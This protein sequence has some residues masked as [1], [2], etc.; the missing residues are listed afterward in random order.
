MNGLPIFNWDSLI[1]RDEAINLYDNVPQHFSRVLI[2]GNSGAGKT[3]VLLTLLYKYMHYDALFLYYKNKTEEKYE[4]FRIFIEEVN[5]QRK[6]E[7][8]RQAELLDIDESQVTEPKDILLYIAHDLNDVIPLSNFEDNDEL[9][10]MT[11]IVVF[12]DFLNEKD[13]K[14]IS[15][16]MI[17]SRK[18]RCTCFYLGQTLH[19]VPQVIRSNCT[20]LI[21]FKHPKRELNEIYKSYGGVLDKEDFVKIFN[22]ATSNKH[23]FLYIR[24]NAP[25]EDMY[26][27][28]LSDPVEIII[29]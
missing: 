20:D 14:I 6:A 4:V 17:Y 21:L 28:G 12:D 3:T 19:K 10:N 26:R 25:Y 13:Q 18:L 9:R 24:I 5:N 1:P 2:A 7:R 27:I 29:E 16:Y 22:I 8:K 11:K 23:G 15:D